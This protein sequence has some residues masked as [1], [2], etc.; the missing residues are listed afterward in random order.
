[1]C[2]CIFFFNLA[3]PDLSCS[4]WD[5]F[6]LP[7]I[8]PRPLALRVWSLN[9][10]ITREIPMQYFLKIKTNAKKKRKKI[11]DK[12]SIENNVDFLKYCIRIFILITKLFGAP[13]KFV[14]KESE[15]LGPLALSCPHPGV[16]STG[17]GGESQR[18]LPAPT[19]Y[20]PSLTQGPEFGVIITLVKKRRPYQVKFWH[21]F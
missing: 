4:M 7:G 9:H 16:V 14:P 13:W 15:F 8:E 2:V 10:W 17:L 6:S 21:S 12:T 3:V 19:S 1:M 18:G 11:Y 5:L 20:V